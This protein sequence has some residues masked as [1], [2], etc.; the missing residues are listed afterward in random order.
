MDVGDDDDPAFD[1]AHG[2][3]FGMGLHF[4]VVARDGR[5]GAGVDIHLFFGHCES[6]IEGLGEFDGVLGGVC[7]RVVEC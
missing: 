3:G 5:R 2:G 6:L 4:G 7:G 1:G